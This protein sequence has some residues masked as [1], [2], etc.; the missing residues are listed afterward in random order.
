MMAENNSLH[1]EEVDNASQR[2]V[3]L[4]KLVFQLFH[5]VLAAAILL[6]GIV[7]FSVEPSIF[8][9]F[10]RENYKT[11]PDDDQVSN[12]TGYLNVIR[13]QQRLVAVG[14]QLSC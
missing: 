7:E 1:R 9:V 4:V 3:D 12:S 6:I 5:L 2:R 13:V 11:F 8:D 14:N 10:G